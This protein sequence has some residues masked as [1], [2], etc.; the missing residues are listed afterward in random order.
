MRGPCILWPR[1][2]SRPEVAGFGCPID[3]TDLASNGQLPLPDG[4]VSALQGPCLQSNRAHGQVC[5][6]D[7]YQGDSA[8][9]QSNRAHAS[10]GL[11]VAMLQNARASDSSLTGVLSNLEHKE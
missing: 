5:S 11:V 4:C 6:I 1:R 2:H 3:V 9:A 8:C 10:G 7:E